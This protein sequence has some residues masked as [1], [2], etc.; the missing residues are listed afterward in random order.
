[1]RFVQDALPRNELLDRP[2]GP[3]E[4]DYARYPRG[5]LAEYSRLY[6]NDGLLVVSCANHTSTGSAPGP[7]RNCLC[8]FMASKRWRIL[9]LAR[10]SNETMVSTRS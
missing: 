7:S 10:G 8:A 5:T 4:P 9:V 6:N 2:T 1:M 3:T